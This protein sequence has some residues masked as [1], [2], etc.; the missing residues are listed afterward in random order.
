MAIETI[1]INKFGR[2]AG[3]NNI[4]TTML[5][6]DLEGINELAY[7]DSVEKE[8]VP[9]AGKYPIGRG[10]GNYTANCS[11]TLLKE[12]VDALQLSLGPGKRLT[13]I[14]PFDIAVSYDYLGKIYKD[15]IRNC[16][17]TGRS[18]EVK[19]NDKSIVTK[20]ELIVSHIDWNVV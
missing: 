11:I 20:F 5:G 6:R 13:D 1:L 12:E 10:E 8:N 16:E 4:T 14:A 15:R 9:G 7:G 17:F 18:V 19:Q 3:W 2:V